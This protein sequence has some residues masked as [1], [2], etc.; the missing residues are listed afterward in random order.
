M[1]HNQAME[2]SKHRLERANKTYAEAY[3]N[4][5]NTRYLVANNRAY[6][7]IFYAMRAILAL[8][9]VDYKKHSGVIAH[10][11]EN[12]IKTKHLDKKLS[13][14]VRNASIIRNKSDYE[15]FYTASKEEA[16][17]QVDDANMFIAAVEEYLQNR[18]RAAG[19]EG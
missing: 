7:A 8:D 9:G 17:A 1:S 19:A 10:F 16:A 2:L 18:W 14:I 3:E 6:Y 4:L 11:R 5:E 13:D 15:D 12:Y